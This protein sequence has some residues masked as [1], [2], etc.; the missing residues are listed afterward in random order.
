MRWKVP[1]S[2]NVP[3]SINTLLANVYSDLI[4]LILQKLNRSI[5]YGSSPFES[6]NFRSRMLTDVSHDCIVLLTFVA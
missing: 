1:D 2:S 3:L 6:M 4:A 5:K